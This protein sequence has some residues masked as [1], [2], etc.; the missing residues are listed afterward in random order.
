[1]TVQVLPGVRASSDE[2][3]SALTINDPLLERLLSEHEGP[4]NREQLRRRPSGAGRVREIQEGERHIGDLHNVPA[5]K[6]NHPDSDIRQQIQKQILTQMWG[7]HTGYPEEFY[8]AKDTFR[9]DAGM[10]F[11][12]H[13]RP[14]EGCIDWQDDSK[15]LTDKD[16]K[17]RGAAMGQPR[18]DVFLCTFCPVAVW[19]EH[20]KIVK[21][22]LDA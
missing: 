17:Q 7:D 14:K 10:C 13:G 9:E 6:W 12:R 15:R 22:G 11:N 5:S 8:A 18:T 3:R 21:A 19:V 1:M 20:Q 16:W 2:E 4:L